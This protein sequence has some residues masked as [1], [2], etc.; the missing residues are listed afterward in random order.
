[1]AAF[2]S[3]VQETPVSVVSGVPQRALCL[4]SYVAAVLLANIFLDTFVALP[5][6]GLFSIGSIFFAAVFT[7]RDRLHMYG[8][9]AVYWGIALALLVNFAYGHWVAQ[10]SPRFLLASFTSILL[11]ELA[12]T[13]VF[14][15]LR[16]RRWQTRVLVSNAVSVPL[17]SL[18][19]TLL[20]FAG[21]MSAYDI[22]Q[23]V[24]ADIVGK[25]LIAALLAYV[26]FIR[27]QMW[28]VA[29]A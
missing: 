6:F 23:I 13:A 19:F 7:L 17:D 26:P 25:Y 21:I 27:P 2:F 11:S 3:I 9:R 22:A 10:I 24:Y 1:M 12:D 8:L 16:R 4:C 5:L 28:M 14:A 18:A 29:K 15:R 20:A